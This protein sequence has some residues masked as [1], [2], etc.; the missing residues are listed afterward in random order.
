[1]SVTRILDRPAWQHRAACRGVPIHVFF[2]ERGESYETAAELCERCPVRRE[3]L[4]YAL[5]DP[6]LDG[7]WAGTTP[8]ERGRMRRAAG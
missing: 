1:M 6:L 3:C 5:A 8:R 4:A 2:V 7:Y